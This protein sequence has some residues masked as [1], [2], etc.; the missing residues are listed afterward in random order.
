MKRI[1]LFMKK[2]VTHSFLLIRTGIIIQRT[3]CDQYTFLPSYFDSV[4]PHDCICFWVI[5][6]IFSIIVIAHLFTYCEG[7]FYVFEIAVILKIF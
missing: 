4:S 1:M 2:V 5:Q 6:V 7:W 3:R